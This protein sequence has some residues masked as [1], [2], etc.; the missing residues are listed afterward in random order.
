MSLTIRCDHFDLD[1]GRC[2]A[3]LTGLAFGAYPS[4]WTINILNPEGDHMDYCAQ[5]AP[6]RGDGGCR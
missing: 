1:F 5:H 2:E 4:S 6:A 3:E